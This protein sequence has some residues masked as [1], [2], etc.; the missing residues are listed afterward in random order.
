MMGRRGRDDDGVAMILV[1]IYSAVLLLMVLVV[2]Q[3]VIASVR[4]SDVSES[5]YGAL[6][7]AEAG[8][9]DYRSRLDLA[10]VTSRVNSPAL[11]G[12]VRIPGTASDAYFTYAL[13][14]PADATDTGVVRLRST[15]RVNGVTRTVEATLTKRTTYDYAYVSSSESVPWNF[16]GAYSGSGG[17]LTPTQALE[18]CR[19][20]WYQP[21]RRSTAAATLGPHR[22]SRICKFVAVK[23][24][25]RWEGNAHTND[26][27]YFGPGLGDVFKGVVTTSC[28]LGDGSNGCPSGQRWINP[29][30]VPPGNAANPADY[31]QFE[32]PSVTPVTWNPQYA[33][34]LEFP[35]DPSDL[36]SRAQSAG[37]YFTGPTRIRWF[38]GGVVT[39]TSPST[40][41]ASIN[42]FCREVGKSYYAGST[43]TTQTTMVL[44]ITTMKAAGFNG[45]FYVDSV[46]EPS[47]PSCASKGSSIYP[48][49]IPSSTAY[50]ETANYAFP[51]STNLWSS[52]K[53]LGFP[54][55]S[56]KSGEPWS[57]D[58]CGKGTAYIQ[59]AY[60]G[61][62]T[63]AAAH[64]IAITGQLWDEQLQNANWQNPSAADYA[65]PPLTSPNT[66]GLIPQR[67]LYIYLPTSSDGGGS[68]NSPGASSCTPVNLN[69]CNLAINAASLVLNGCFAVQ[70]FDTTVARGVLRWVGSLAQQSRCTVEKPS[71][72][73]GYKPFSIY[74]D[75]R[76]ASSVAPPYM[77][78]LFTEPWSLERIAELNPG[79]VQVPSFP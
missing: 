70:D 62:L 57:L 66:L 46:T 17:E 25:D 14:P 78:D 35:P 39:I 30:V 8:I 3:A 77:A 48:F 72:N 2:G 42:S 41:D 34:P 20:S 74:Y 53:V 67:Y 60:R 45:I 32:I 50:P 51:P 19:N 61:E 49:V 12:W 79:S 64:D 10:G 44:N 52:G 43:P 63:L 24:A 76:L 29:S 6:A 71:G 33:S 55:D 68:W 73:G 15:G 47:P 13:V 69:Q 59:G 16:P 38:P 56:T 5:S 1:I 22:N 26:T 54:V 11:T 27:W 58:G 65:V 37:C 28:P 21:A 31:V 4:S 40:S 18:F 75:K 9:D 23:S 7:A 36:R